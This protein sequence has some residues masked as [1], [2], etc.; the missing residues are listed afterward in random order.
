MLCRIL[1]NLT[2]QSLQTIAKK[3]KIWCK[4]KSEVRKSE[5]TNFG[6]GYFEGDLIF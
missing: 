2:K 1:R 4:I 5:M 6:G 3:K